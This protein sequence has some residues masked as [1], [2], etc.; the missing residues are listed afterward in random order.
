M[1][2]AVRMERFIQRQK[3]IVLK[4]NALFLSEFVGIL[5]ETVNS[6]WNRMNQHSCWH[7][8]CC[9][10]AESENA[11]AET[12]GSECWDQGFAGAKP[13][14]TDDNETA[15]Y[16]AFSGMNMAQ[17]LNMGLLHLLHSA[18]GARQALPVTFQRH[19]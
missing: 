13:P 4:E 16:T 8:A 5:E 6:D 1:V 12:R 19:C 9:W 17:L 10:G 2:T 15:T 11:H 7:A 18:K 14:F 3:G